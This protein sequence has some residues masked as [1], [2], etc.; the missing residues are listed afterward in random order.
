[1]LYMFVAMLSYSRAVCDEFC[2]SMNT[3]TFLRCHERAFAYWGGVPRVIL[4]DN[5]KGVV[6]GRLGKAVHFNDEILSLSGFHGF[7]PR[8]CHPYRGN[9]KGRVERTIHYLRSNYL[10]TRPLTNL[11]TMNATLL[12]W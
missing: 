5:L 4:Y 3:A 11:T 12:A 2:L 7:E 10:Q 1:M 9:E 6:L 8:P